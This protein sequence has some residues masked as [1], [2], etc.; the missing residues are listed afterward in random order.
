MDIGVFIPI[1]NNGWLISTT[2]PQ[3]M[4]T[5]ELNKQ[6]VQRAERLRLRLRPLDDQAA[7]LRRQER[8]LG[9]QP[10]VLHPDGGPGRRHQ[11]HQALRLG[12]RADHAAGDRGAHGLDHRLDLARPLRRQ[13]RLRLGQGRVRPD[14]PV[15]G[16]RALRQ[17][18]RLQHR[19][20]H[21]HAR[22]VGDRA[23]RTSRASTSTMDDCKLS[24]RPQA[25]IEDRLRRPEP[26]RHASSAPSYGDYNFVAG[27]GHQ[28][29]DRARGHQPAR[30]PRPP[31]RPAAMSATT[32][33]SWSS[34]TRPTRRPWPSGSTTTTAPTSTRWRGWPAR[35]MPTPMPPTAARPPDMAAARRARSTSTWARWSAP[36]PR[37]RACWT[38]CA[39]GARHQGHHAGLRRLHRSAWRSSASASSR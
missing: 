21:H 2:S 38:R 16:R 4:P 25:D 32:C 17:A 29:A 36:T 24:P 3:Y 35:P 33:C 7:R 9:P 11:A 31:A 10:G 19:V 26:A 27:Q 23:V 30:W 12:R 1:G 15:A 34:P 28:H 37:S 20:R 22:A 8:V 13:H 5:F 39:D 18:L 6:V 14:G